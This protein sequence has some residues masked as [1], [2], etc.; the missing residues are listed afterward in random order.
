MLRVQ[1]FI[2]FNGIL[3]RYICKVFT[4]V[5]FR[6][7]AMQ[8]K[9]RLRIRVRCVGTILQIRDHDSSF[10][11]H[12][13]TGGIL[14]SRGSSVGFFFFFSLFISTC[15]NCYIM[16]RNSYLLSTIHR[17]YSKSRMR[18]IRNTVI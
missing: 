7:S 13:S 8:R 9:S 17:A 16:P 15:F 4:S 18:A 3:V 2:S 14:L 1:I 5:S 11:H 10:K 6:F 12:R